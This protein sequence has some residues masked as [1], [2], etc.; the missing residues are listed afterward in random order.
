MR[1]PVRERGQALILLGAWL[2][3]G[4]GATTALLVY[5]RPPS[6]IKKVIKQVITDEGRRGKILSEIRQWE[7]GQESLDERV[8]AYRKELLKSFRNKGAQRS[9][10]E[11]ILARL[12]VNLQEMDRNFLDLRFKIKEQVTSAEWA[13]IV[14]PYPAK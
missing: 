13:R 12:D 1:A 2:F 7:S 9:D 11:P 10:V 14:V 5:D 6:E 3:F 8:S 4:G